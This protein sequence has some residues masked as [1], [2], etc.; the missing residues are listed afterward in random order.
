MEWNELKEMFEMGADDVSKWLNNEYGTIRSG[1]VSLS[2]FDKVRVMAY[3]EEMKLN[4]VANIQI[5]SATQVVVKPYDRGQIQ[6]ILKGISISQIN[7]N[8]I[9]NPDCI[10][11]NFPAKTEETRKENVKKAK[12]LLEDAKVKLRDVRRV[13]QDKY[14][15]LDGVSEDVIHYFE[16]ELNKIT[17]QWTTKLEQAYQAKEKELMSM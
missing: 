1:R 4:Q 3:G 5:V 15:K 6:E 9:V 10:R 8:P 7:A 16:D 12:K 17:K 11:I 2:V 13:V 14:K